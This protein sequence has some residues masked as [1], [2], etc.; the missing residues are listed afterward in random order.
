MKRVQTRLLGLAVLCAALASTGCE[1]MSSAG[2]SVTGLFGSD[3]SKRPD[4]PTVL[5]KD[6]KPSIEVVEVWS[7]RIGKGT[8]DL[9]LK[10]GPAVIDDALFVADHA[11]RLAATD[12]ETGKVRWDIHD[13][14][15]RYTGG[16]GGDGMVLV[17]TG[18]GRVIARESA[19]GKLKWVAKVSSEV[20]APPRA[21]RGMAV[22]RT[23]T[24]RCSGWIPPPGPASG[25]TTCRCLR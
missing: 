11:G 18:D 4:A 6:F 15:V 16:P 24:A 19:T 1:T 14:K 3:D 12:L 17:G 23:G 5:S 10:L 21:E 8:E 9:Y 2:R 20:L 13:K 22:A 7:K 25:S